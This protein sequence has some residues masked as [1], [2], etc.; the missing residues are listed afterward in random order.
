MPAFSALPLKTERLVL[1][2][3]GPQDASA[4]FAIYSDP[5]AMRYWGTPA[6][7]KID[8]AVAMI[9]RETIALEAGEHLRLGIERQVDGEFI[10]ACTLFSFHESSRRAE[11]GYILAP[12]C[13]G[14]GYMSESL[15]AL[16]GYGFKH[17]NLNRIEADID[18][19]NERS[20]KVLLRLGF[21]HE[22][23][24]RQRWIVSGEV[25]DT[26]LFGLLRADWER[27]L[28]TLQPSGA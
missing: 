7:S 25:S 6:W 17:L 9:E 19:R 1:R 15:S 3:L 28:V 22:G 12:D 8:Q 2:P 16:V 11:I 13:W 24:L 5:K 27:T 21:I 10:G 18:P 20:A 23:L 14:Q 4:L 26:G